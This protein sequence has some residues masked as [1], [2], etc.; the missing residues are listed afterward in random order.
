MICLFLFRDER[1]YVLFTPPVLICIPVAKFVMSYC[2]FNLLLV[3]LSLRISLLSPVSCSTEKITN[4]VLSRSRQWIIRVQNGNL[5]NNILIFF[6]KKMYV[7]TPI[8]LN[9]QV[10]KLRIFSI[11]KL[12]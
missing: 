5:F 11:N 2:T 6:H 9:I 3:G 8:I 1:F 12:N 4:Y 7:C 10:N